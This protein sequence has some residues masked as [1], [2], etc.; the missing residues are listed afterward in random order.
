MIFFELSQRGDIL[1][2]NLGDC[3]FDV[4]KLTLEVGRSA[5]WRHNGV[6]YVVYT[7]ELE[8]VRSVIV[9]EGD[10]DLSKSPRLRKSLLP[11]LANIF[12]D[13]VKANVARA[14]DYTHS[15]NTLH[16][17]MKQK[18]EGYAEPTEF[19]G[20]TYADVRERIKSKIAS[21]LNSASDTIIYLSKRVADMGAHLRGFEVAEAQE[22]IDLNDFTPTRLK[23]ALL[24]SFSAIQ[25]EMYGDMWIKLKV[26]IPNDV[27]VNVDRELLNLVLYNIFD[28]TRK[29]ILIDSEIHAGWNEESR[30]L[31]I[32][33][34]SLAVNQAECNKI[35]QKGYRGEHARV[36][37]D[38]G[39]GLG[40]FVVKRVMELM[41]GNVSFDYRPDK[42]QRYNGELYRE[43]YFRLKFGAISQP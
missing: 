2:T 8:D 20:E 29:Y 32:S 31:A 15:V 11:A 9:V 43:N 34:T 14:N 26:N 13:A 35:F 6:E 21:D 19:Y 28:N 10:K 36:R 40:L 42:D 27:R 39:K 16:G 3:P 24:S 17:K 4:S 30:E 33:M 1:G 41:G 5:K 18:I 12:H 7:D 23:A 37:G 22:E 38:D 25:D